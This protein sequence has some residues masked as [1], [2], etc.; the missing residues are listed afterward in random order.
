MNTRKLATG[1]KN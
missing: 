1:A